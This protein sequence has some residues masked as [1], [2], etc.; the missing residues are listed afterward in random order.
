MASIDTIE[1]LDNLDNAHAATAEIWSV[2]ADKQAG[3]CCI[4]T[5][6]LLPMAAVGARV[7][8]NNAY[9]NTALVAGGSQV[10]ARV[11]LTAVTGI[12]TT[13]V[14]KTQNTQPLEWTAI[15][16]GAMAESAEI[17]L[18]NIMEA[19]LHVDVAISGTT[20]HL[21]TEVIVQVRKEVTTEEWTT[22]SRYVVLSGLTAFHVH[23]NATANAGQKVIGVDNPVAG[24]LDHVNRKLFILDATVANSEIVYQTACGADS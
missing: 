21:G 8:I 23:P 24:N 15:A 20:A 2:D 5:P 22:W 7:I 13:S 4:M 9:G 14:T 10:H 17:D 11:R 12:T 19:V 3:E 16:A 6:I 1:V 18:T